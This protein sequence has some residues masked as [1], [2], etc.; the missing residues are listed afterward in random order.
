MN[1]GG[2]KPGGGGDG[3]GGD[4]G[5]D[6]GFTNYEVT[7][8]HPGVWYSWMHGE[9]QAAWD[10]GYAGAGATIGYSGSASISASDLVLEVDGSV[11]NQFGVFYYGPDQ[12][13]VTFGDGLRCVGR[14]RRGPA[15]LAG[16]RR[17]RRT[18][19]GV[20]ELYS[21]K[22]CFLVFGRV[23]RPLQQRVRLGK[24]LRRLL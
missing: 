17:G 7:L 2:G 3:G 6:T 16:V 9:V 21:A 14:A 20:P 10:L 11:P 1:K 22:E 5:G 15:R 4:G 19:F 18:G 8:T 23:E 24:R 12:D 13:Q